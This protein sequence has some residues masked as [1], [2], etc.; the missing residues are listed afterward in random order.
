MPLHSGLRCMASALMGTLLGTIAQLASPA[1]AATQPF[2]PLQQQIETLRQEHNIPGASVA[3]IQDGRIAWARGFG[4]ADLESSRPVTE[5]TLFQAQSITKTLTSLATV[6]LLAAEE[7]ALDEPVNRYLKGWKVPENDY[8]AKVPVSFRMLL[9]HTGALSNPY[10]D[11]CCGPKETL[12]TL[13]Q[14]LR[15]QPPANNPPLTVERIPGTRYDYCNGCYTVLQPALE[16][17]AQQSFPA[18]MQELVLQPAGMSRSTFD[19]RFFLDDTSSIAIPYDADGTPHQRAPMRNPIL[20]TGL[21]W[22]TA[23]DLARFN[24][25]FTQALDSNHKLLDQALAEQLTIPSSTASRSLG[26]Y[27]GNRDA[28]TQARGQYIFHGGSG[29][30]Y[31]SLSII[32]LDGNHGAVILINKAPN[33]WLTTNIPQYD[34]IISALKLISNFNHWT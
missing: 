9:N 29:N 10:P 8:T 3:V 34:F 19:N 6:K 25:A 22:S 2:S 16:S 31:L 12:P 23:S 33:P 21:M 5:H 18:L 14:L 20:S 24:L 13:P 26:F 7:I 30:G 15:G 1:K 4:M 32:S 11:G 28:G 27:I 17:I